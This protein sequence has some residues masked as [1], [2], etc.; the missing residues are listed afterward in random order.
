MNA[1]N[2][3]MSRLIIIIIIQQLQYNSNKSR[4]TK[5]KIIR[6]HYIIILSN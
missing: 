6:E 3:H 2:N 1:S 5:M 4:L